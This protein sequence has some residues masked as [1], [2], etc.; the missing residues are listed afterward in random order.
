MPAGTWDKLPQYRNYGF[1]V[2]KLKKGEHKMHPMAFEFPRA[3]KSKLFFPTVHIHDGKVHS[4]KRISIMLSYCQ[5]WD[6]RTRWDE[7][8]QPA[9]FFMKKL[10][11]TKGIVTATPTSIASG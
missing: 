10:D 11:Q 4:T 6:T 8:P 7:S 3:D 9:E 5:E 1:A 2:F